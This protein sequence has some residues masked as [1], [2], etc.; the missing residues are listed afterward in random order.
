MVLTNDIMIIPGSVDGIHNY[1][2]KP[3][4]KNST[5]KKIL[6]EEGVQNIE[7]I[8][9]ENPFLK[10]E[11]IEEIHLP[12]TIIN[13]NEKILN[14]KKG[15]IQP[16]YVKFST[17]VSK[18][19][20]D[21]VILGNEIIK[22]NNLKISGDIV[23]PEGIET[24]H[25][26]AF[27]NTPNIQS[28]N[29]PSTIKEIKESAFLECGV[30]KI[31]FNPLINDLVIN[32]S[33]FSNNF[34]LNE[35]ELPE[36]LISIK[37]N[38]FNN[39]PSLKNIT[40]PSTVIEIHPS[41]F[42]RINFSLN[43][44]T[45][46]CIK[47]DILYNDDVTELI[48]VLPANTQKSY[49]I[50]ETVKSIGEFAF[51]KRTDLQCIVLPEGLVSIKE[52]AFSFCS[53]LK[54]I[55]IPNSVETI[56]NSA[57]N[58][59][60]KLNTIKMPDNLIELGVGVF[61]ECA[62]LLEISLPNNLV[63]LKRTTFL[64]CKK[65]QKV[66]MGNK[67][68][69]ICY[70]CFNGCKSLES[71]NLSTKLETLSFSVFSSCSRLKNITLPNTL[72]NIGDSAFKSCNSLESII[73]PDGLKTLGSNVFEKCNSLS[74]IEIPSTVEEIGTSIFKGI[75][76]IKIYTLEK[77]RGVKW[78]HTWNSYFNVYWEQSILKEN[79]KPKEI[80]VT[81]ITEGDFRISEDRT[82]LGDTLVVFN[83]L[84]ELLE[85]LPKSIT[86]LKR[87]SMKCIQR[88]LV[89]KVPKHITKMDLCSAKEV[90]NIEVYDTTSMIASDKSLSESNLY[91]GYTP[92]FNI[93][94]KNPDDSI[95]IKLEFD[96]SKQPGIIKE[97][98]EGT[99]WVLDTAGSFD[100]L[101][102]V[103][104]KVAPKSSK[105]C[106]SATY[107][108]LLTI[109]DVKANEIIMEYISKNTVDVLERLIKNDDL[110]S[111]DILINNNFINKK[112][113]T[114]MIDKAKIL[115][116]QDFLTKLIDLSNSL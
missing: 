92:D 56:G 7:F 116:K 16:D 72:L 84:D 12:S 94:I 40:I 20:D 36:K 57:F 3:L 101:S 48:K 37:K 104:D 66:T 18:S 43:N 9:N 91:F 45:H 42:D 21:I 85:K 89:F 15:Y 58:F 100:S 102:K 53:L 113:I 90:G 29:F 8:E 34:K 70:N 22:L 67:I 112:N 76:N 114:K 69:Q 60:L 38:A 59:C 62:N 99:D 4:A 5:V 49:V 55:V 108:K 73:L 47:D 80:K 2:F 106:L 93:T 23:I 25:Q 95:K 98:L 115:N 10:F 68:K 51:F 17:N 96:M 50:P 63:E 24:I 109:Q 19:S 105:V 44:N 11:N 52:G 97:T 13:F 74:T 82:I 30:Q 83:T 75:T 81:Y 111:V 41:A 103:F 78:N 27:K 86:T 54:E 14:N 88:N 39:L 79:T 6:F 46:F 26:K 31:T 87:F 110:S 1:S 64:S 65:L 33:A 28:I 61:A 32:E 77:S 71:I 107:C 35:V